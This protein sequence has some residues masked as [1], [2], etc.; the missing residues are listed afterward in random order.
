MERKCTN[1]GGS[2]K[3]MR[4]GDVYKCPI[5]EGTGHPTRKSYNSRLG[6]QPIKKKKKKSF[7]GVF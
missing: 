4:F 6:Y 5:C 1:C 7:G 2:G 3:L